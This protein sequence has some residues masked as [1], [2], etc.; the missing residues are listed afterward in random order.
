M[1]TIIIFL[2]SNETSLLWI[3]SLLSMIIFFF[4]SKSLSSLLL[5]IL[6]KLSFK[7]KSHYDDILLS[8]FKKPL[9]WFIISFGI[10]FS[11]SFFD[12]SL[13]FS[14][15]ITHLFR[16]IVVI[17]IG[18]G[19]FNLSVKSSGLFDFLH[20][21]T[22][23]NIDRILI[24]FISRSIQT[25]IIFLVI[26]VIAEEWGYD[27]NGFV[28]G[29]GIGGLAFAFAAKDTLSNLLSGFILILE[30][31]FSIGHWIKIGNTEGTVEDI[32]LRSTKIR[33]FSQALVSVPNSQVSNIHI[34]NFSKMNK[35]RIT[36]NLG[37]NYDTPRIKIQK[38]IDEI[39]H[40]LKNNSEIH[41]E[42]IFVHF[43]EFNSSS[44]DIFLYFFTKTTNWSEYLKTRESVNLKIL[45]IIERNEV[46]IAF[47]SQTLYIEK[48]DE[49]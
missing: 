10:Y 48:N 3:K 17:L 21:K 41:Q 1:E 9:Q 11:L 12:F 42:T 45:E 35:R 38:C 26:A 29:L 2:S 46:S 34:T 44:L 14:D 5:T 31:P 39:H 25:I 16:S 22:D 7:T 33:T 23:I 4:L 8:A 36:F 27:V 47:P 6:S 40:Y 49:F 18:T 13:E 19:L 28:A 20:N 24:P 15:I 37:L 32:N 43:N 30:K